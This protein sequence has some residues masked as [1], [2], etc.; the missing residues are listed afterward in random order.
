LISEEG[1]NMGDYEWKPIDFDHPSILFILEDMPKGFIGCPLFYNTYYRAFGLKGNEKVLDFGCGGGAGSRCLIRFLGNE[2]HLT[3]VDISRFWIDRAKRRLAR[4]SN[5]TCRA[6]D[7]K[8]MDIP[9]C[10]FDVVTTIHTIHDIGPAERQEV[11]H[12]LSKKL[13]DG[14]CFFI[15]E[16]I[17]KSHGMPVEEIRS[18]LTNAGLNEIEHAITKSEYQG[19]FEKIIELAVNP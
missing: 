15:R 13:K 14:G 9:N 19:T 4:F 11:I 6:G 18:L 7:I 12:A 17:K 3:C 5:T 8:T 1:G 2:A 10:S 16:P